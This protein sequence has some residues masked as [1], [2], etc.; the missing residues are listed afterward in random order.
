MSHG[1]QGGP[2]APNRTPKY[3]KDFEDLIDAMVTTGLSALECKP[4]SDK[5]NW[6]SLFSRVEFDVNQFSRDYSTLPKRSVLS[7]IS[8]LQQFLHDMKAFLAADAALPVL[9]NRLPAEIVEMVIKDLEVPDADAL[10][11]SYIVE[12]PNVKCSLDAGACRKHNYN[13]SEQQ[14]YYGAENVEWTCPEGSTVFYWSCSKRTFCHTHYDDNCQEALLCRIIDCKGHLSRAGWEMDLEEAQEYIG[15][16]PVLGPLSEVLPLKII[17]E[18]L[19]K[20]ELLWEK[21]RCKCNTWTCLY[22]G[23]VCRK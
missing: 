1:S 7:H 6:W 11:A 20:E 21:W 8:R 3:L 18:P 9:D 5:Q 4:M 19:T 17:R 14:E 12:W 10:R 13:Q 16:D 2:G 15:V 23:D 22:N